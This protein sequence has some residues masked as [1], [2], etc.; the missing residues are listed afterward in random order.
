MQIEQYVW[1]LTPEGM[2]VILY[3]MTNQQGAYVKLT[4]LGAAIVAV[5]VPD[6]HGKID[7]VALGYEEWSSYQGDG[8]AM[9]KSVGRYANRIARGRFTLDGAD[10][11]LAVNNGPNHLHGGPTGFANRLWEARVET[12]RV[13]FAYQSPDGEEN[14]PGDLNVEACYDWGDDNALIITYYGRVDGK[15]TILNLTNHVYFNLKGDG[16]GDILDHTLQLNASH[17]LPT[18][19]TAIPTGELQP[20]EGT[21][22]DF[23]TPHLI[24]QRIEQPYEHLTIGKGYDHCWAID[25]WTPGQLTAAGTLSEASTGR[26]IEILTTQPGIQIYTGNWLAGSPAGKHGQ[27]YIDRSGVALECQ[28][29]PD[30]PNKPQFPGNGAV[31]RPGETYK[32]QI[33]YKFSLL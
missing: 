9:G 22:M 32:Q 12:D 6:K 25:G 18:D 31:L 7:D 30:T 24:G 29:F 23:R 2:P 5:G 15:A 27:Q 4:N 1:G 13:V 11:H 19:P 21:P 33:V 10:Y 8:A 3:T 17:F 14:Y 28:L 26:K 16:Q 20:V